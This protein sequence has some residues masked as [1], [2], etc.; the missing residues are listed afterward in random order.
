[1]EETTLKE[2]IHQVL[3][4]C[5]VSLGCAACVGATGAW[6]ALLVEV[7]H[8]AG[9]KQA[10]AKTLWCWLTDH[11]WMGWRSHLEIIRFISAI[12][13]NFQDGAHPGREPELTSHLHGR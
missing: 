4:D 9:A 5:P 3:L 11:A 10:L 2:R 12:G 7:H 8:G 13:E 1:M 6:R